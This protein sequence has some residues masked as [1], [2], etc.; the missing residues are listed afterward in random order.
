MH[1]YP[2]QSPRR[3][4]FGL[5]PL[6][7]R[8]SSLGTINLNLFGRNQGHQSHDAPPLH[9]NGVVRPVME[10]LALDMFL[11]AS[12]PRVLRPIMWLGVF[13]RGGPE[14]LLGSMRNQLETMAPGVSLPGHRRKNPLAPLF[15]LLA[16]WMKLIAQLAALQSAGALLATC[17]RSEV[18]TGDRAAALAAGNAE[19]AAAAIMRV[20]GQ[21]PV[22]S[23]DGDELEALLREAAESA[24][25]QQW[26]LRREAMISRW[27][28]PAPEERVRALLQWSETRAADSTCWHWRRCGGKR[29]HHPGAGSI[30]SYLQERIQCR[31][32]GGCTSQG[33]L[34]LWQW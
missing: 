23:A 1:G 30:G 29:L 9:A 8:P 11:K 26:A 20:F 12:A 32:S 16:P 25:R 14:A 2:G 33:I 15:R 7:H 19:D 4:F 17:G 27:T 24:Q 28:R 34:P 3:S 6:G 13:L 18:I 10:F 31:Q 22:E 21:M 5:D